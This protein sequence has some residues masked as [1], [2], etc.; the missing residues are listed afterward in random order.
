M[1]LSEQ[2][3]RLLDEMERQ[4]MHTDADVVHASTSRS[5]SYR[6]LLIGTLLVL[7]GLGGVIAGIALW[8]VA[9]IAA[10]VVGVIGFAA[11]VAGVII[12]FAPGKGTA[13]SAESDPTPQS[14]SSSNASFMDKMN[15]RWDR[16]HHS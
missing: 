12:A 8:N 3:Q 10:V 2:E 7:V 1:P 4:L 11:M 15:D 5:F 14:P 6:N 9:I 13:N 16:R